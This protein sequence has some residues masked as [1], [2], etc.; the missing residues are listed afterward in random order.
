MPDILNTIDNILE[1]ICDRQSRSIVDDLATLFDRLEV[2]EDPLIANALEEQIWSAWCNHADEDA[3]DAMNEVLFLF[4]KG[5]G[6]QAETVLDDMV[7]RWPD[8]PEVWNKRAT[9]YFL[10]DRDEDSL[11]SIAQTLSLEPRHFVAISVF[12]Q[13]CMRHDQY[14]VALMALETALSIS[15]GMYQLQET[16]ELLPDHVSVEPGTDDQTLH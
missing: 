6:D 15:P 8:W 1:Q 16:V 9:L 10:D 13:I 3:V 4:E 12:A 11:D 7:Q 2:N 5:D 14:R